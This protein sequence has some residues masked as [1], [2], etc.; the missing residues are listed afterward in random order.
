MLV[1]LDVLAS[2]A[3]QLEPL[4]ASVGRLFSVMSSDDWS[5]DEIEDV[6]RL[7]QALTGR[8]LSIANS[9][10]R[11]P[12]R[13]IATVREAVIRLG[14]G[15]V[16]SVAVAL[17]ASDRLKREL[18]GYGAKAGD[19]WRHSVAALLAAEEL[20]PICGA[21]PEVVSGALLHDIGK[22]LLCQHCD[23][24]VWRYM[25]LARDRASGT[26]I[27]LETEVL[28]VHHGELGG[29]MAQRWGLPDGIVAGITHHHDPEV[30]LAEPHRRTC[31]VIYLADR[32]ANRI[33]CTLGATPSD[34]DDAR[35]ADLEARV[36]TGLGLEP[37]RLEA[38]CQKVAD[39]LEA[40]L[41]AYAS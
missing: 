15:T 6:V 36:R 2:E 21:T 10:F 17:A 30:T 37:R 9:A 27:E 7:D 20:I 39:R 12:V 8:V 29:L 35:E 32:I 13:R 1:D 40:T 34:E 23:P 14:G 16:V 22:L 28:E 25:R 24:S 3:Q 41:E 11:G 4:P 19:L 18:P 38:L 31:R 33:G 5:L 26:Q